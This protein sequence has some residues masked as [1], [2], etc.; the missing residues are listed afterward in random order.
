MRKLQHV[1]KGQDTINHIME[2]NARIATAKKTNG[3]CGAISSFIA[4]TIQA[5]LQESMSSCMGASMAGSTDAIH[6]NTFKDDA[7]TGSINVPEEKR[8]RVRG[9]RKI[10]NHA[11]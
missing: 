1:A 8:N 6:G 3:L 9:S 10:S 7:K 4:S 5:K 2:T 11:E